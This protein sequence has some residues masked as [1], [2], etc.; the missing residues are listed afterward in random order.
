[1][2]FKWSSIY[3]DDWVIHYD[4]L[5]NKKYKYYWNNIPIRFICKPFLNG[6]NYESIIGLVDK[7]VTSHSVNINEIQDIIDIR[8]EKLNRIL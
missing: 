3:S 8:D 7:G 1:M 5:I 4:D 2:M 6:N